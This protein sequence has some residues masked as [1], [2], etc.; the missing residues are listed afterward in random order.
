MLSHRGCETTEFFSLMTRLRNLWN[1]AI[2]RSGWGALA[3][4][5]VLLSGASVWAADAEGPGVDGRAI[6]IL[7]GTVLIGLVAYAMFLYLRP[8]L[9]DRDSGLAWAALLL[10][11]IGIVKIALVPLFRVLE[12]TS[13]HTKPG[14]FG[15]WMWVRRAPIS[16]GTSSI[17]R[18][19]TS[20]R[21]GPRARWRMPSAP[22]ATR[23]D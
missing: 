20:T 8:L 19:A 6:G 7:T 10:L 4:S 22:P 9:I 2:A 12:S 5:F 15:W 21:Y 18:L 3:L 23:C 1:L 14:H 17:T 13:E 16:L 11:A